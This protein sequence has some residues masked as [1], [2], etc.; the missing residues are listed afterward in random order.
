MDIDDS[1]L[2]LLKAA[3][4]ILANRPGW[5]IVQA[6]SE[7]YKAAHLKLSNSVAPDGKVTVINDFVADP[8]EPLPRIRHQW[9]GGILRFLASDVGVVF[10]PVSMTAPAITPEQ[11]TQTRS[12]PTKMRN[13]PGP[14][15]G[16][17]SRHD[18]RDIAAIPEFERLVA[19]LG[20]VKASERLF[21]QGLIEGSSAVSAGRR[22]LNLF[23]KRRTTLKL[24][25]R[26]Q[27]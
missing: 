11:P 21:V 3:T 26:R 20:K 22:F 5:T 6:K 15:T 17:V 24:V 18:Q 14:K 4:I 1:W 12:P 19:T 8:K 10:A 9:L 27:R 13:K 16:M 23:N 7:L 2:T 25:Q